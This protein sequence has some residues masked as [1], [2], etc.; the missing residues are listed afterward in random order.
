[1]CGQAIRHGV[2]IGRV[3]FVGG[4][5]RSIGLTQTTW[6]AQ[7]NGI[8]GETSHSVYLCNVGERKHSLPNTVRDKDSIRREDNK[9]KYAFF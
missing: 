6:I 9:A 3:W 7:K 5:R 2:R 4:N 8:K 1:M